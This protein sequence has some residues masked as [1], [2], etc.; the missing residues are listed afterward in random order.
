M[1]RSARTIAAPAG[2]DPP[3]LVESYDKKVD[4]AI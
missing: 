3:G 1:R 4:A 2:M